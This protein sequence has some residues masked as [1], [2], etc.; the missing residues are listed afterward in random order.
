MLGTFQHSTEMEDD[1][2]HNEQKTNKNPVA[3]SPQANYTD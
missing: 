1:L 3:L 2:F